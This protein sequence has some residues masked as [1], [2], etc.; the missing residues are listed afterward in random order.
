MFL[1]VSRVLWLRLEQLVAT[2]IPRKPE[3][4]VTC[5]VHRTEEPDVSSEKRNKNAAL[6]SPAAPYNYPGGEGVPG[7]GGEV[8]ADSRANAQIRHLAKAKQQKK[9]AAGFTEVSNHGRG[10]D[11]SSFTNDK[12]SFP[13]KKQIHC[14]FFFASVPLDMGLTK[15]PKNT[16]T[17]LEMTMKS[18]KAGSL[19]PCLKTHAHLRWFQHPISQQIE[20]DSCAATFGTR[21][22]NP[23]VFVQLLS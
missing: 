16:K 10:E 19:Q 14:S 9:T 5:R 23:V 18:R 8:S 20:S 12:K 4:P 3:K 17:H 15:E 7:S 11:A 2:W 21:F 6:N 13:A 22:G 1:Q